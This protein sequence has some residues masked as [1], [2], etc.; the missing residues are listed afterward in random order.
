[1]LIMF[2]YTAPLETPLMRS[3][4][5]NTTP[6]SHSRSWSLDTGEIKVKIVTLVAG[7]VQPNSE[8]KLPLCDCGTKEAGQ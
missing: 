5:D 6:V 3:R 4:C 1:M 7:C 8:Q 2:I